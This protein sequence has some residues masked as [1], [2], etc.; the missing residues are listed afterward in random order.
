MKYNALIPFGTSCIVADILAELGFR[1]YSYPFDWVG[2]GDM[3]TRVDI[4]LNDFCD[5]FNIYDFIEIPPL[6]NTQK[7]FR[8]FLNVKTDMT[9]R[10]HFT[11]SLSD[12]E[13]FNEYIDVRNKYNRRQ[14][15]LIKHLSSHNSVLLITVETP[16]RPKISSPTELISMHEKMQAKFSASC[17]DMLYFSLSDMERIAIF[18]PNQHI[19][20]VNT[21]YCNNPDEGL[22]IK[23]L[24]LRVFNL[25]NIELI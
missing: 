7:K 19:T 9:F 10:H 16:R 5:W 17:I 2:G 15:R 12:A 21:H 20:V 8:D 18:Q 24:M 13:F 25:N 22:D 3:K 6:D 11:K 23:D 4:L 1:N 14:S